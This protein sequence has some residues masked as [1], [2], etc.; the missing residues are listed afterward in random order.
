MLPSMGS[1]RVRHDWEAEQKQQQ[2]TSIYKTDNQQRP[3]I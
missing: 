2:N 1:Q 3:T